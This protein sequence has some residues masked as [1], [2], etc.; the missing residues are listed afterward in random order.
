MPAEDALLGTATYARIAVRIDGT[1][2]AVS[3][4]RDSLGIEPFVRRWTAVEDRLLGTAP[5]AE[6]AT[7]LNRTVEAVRMKRQKNEV[8]TFRGS[9]GMARRETGTVVEFF[10][11]RS[12]YSAFVA[13]HLRSS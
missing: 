6:I 10:Q 13:L 8:A 4:R 2:R 3:W 5:D 7:K 11:A 9:G 1:P 12:T